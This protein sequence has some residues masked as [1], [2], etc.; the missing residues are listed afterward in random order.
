MK[1]Q[2]A[3]E[4]TQRVVRVIRQ[5][6]T[7]Q[8]YRDERLLNE[9][10]IYLDDPESPEELQKR[11]ELLE[12]LRKLEQVCEQMEY[13]QKPI[14]GRGVAKQNDQGR[15]E[16]DGRELT[17]GACIEILVQDEDWDDY[18]KW[19]KTI[20]EHDGDYYTTYRHL[21]L[22]GLMVRYR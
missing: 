13:L 5:E 11:E 21:R 2:K 17:S 7:V 12:V 8:D 9:E 16:V 4:K 3:L 1:T 15:F 18:P 6:L 10:D 20:V 22:D 14:R 19:Q